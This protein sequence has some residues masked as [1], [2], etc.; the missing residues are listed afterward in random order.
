MADGTATT[1]AVTRQQLDALVSGLD[2]KTS[3]R[4]ATTATIT[5]TGP[6][7]TIDGVS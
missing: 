1:D 7:A 6:G 3:C 2:V 4:V 5:L